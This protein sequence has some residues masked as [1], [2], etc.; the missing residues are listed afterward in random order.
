MSFSKEFK[1]AISNLPDKEKDKLLF[2]LLRK[3]MKLANRL[4]FEL[5]SD[6]SVEEEREKVREALGKQIQSISND[7][8]SIGYLSMD[9]RSLSGIINEHVSTTKDKIGEIELNIFL[10]IE[11]LSKNKD[12]IFRSHPSK[13]QKF[14]TAVVARVFKILLLINKLHPDFRLEFKD[15]LAELGNIIGDNPYI[16]KMAI[17]NGL[18]V[19]WLTSRD[20]PED[21]E[22]I[23]KDLRSR[24]YL[25]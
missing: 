7:H 23:Y 14:S 3:D 16:M 24:G 8:Y 4:Y 2:R 9:V 1:E 20:I 19:N 6:Y 15:E 17:F 18:D 5:I 11:V 13:A 10:L 12:R 25:R 21:I 22:E